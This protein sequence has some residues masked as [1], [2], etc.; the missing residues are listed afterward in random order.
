MSPRR[1]PRARDLPRS[2]PRACCALPALAG[3]SSERRGGQ[4]ARGPGHR[5]RRPGPGR[6]RRHPAL[7][8]GR[9]CPRPS[10]PS[11]RTPTRPR[12]RVA[13]RVLPSMFRLDAQ[14][15]PQR[16]ADYPG[17]REGRRH[18]AQA[19]RALQAQPAG[20][21]GATAA[22][23]APP[24]SPPSGA[25]C[26]ART[27]R[28]GRP[29]TPATTAS[30]R[31]SA[32][33][34][35]CEVRVTFARPY[36]DWRSLFS[37]L[38][39]KDVMGTPDAFNDGARRK[40]KVTAGP[41]AAA[42]GRHARTAQ[43]TL[44]RNPRW[45]GRPAKLDKMVPA[46]PC[47]ATSGPRRWPRARSTS[48]RSTRPTPGRIASRPRQ[49][50]AAARHQAQRPPQAA[51]WAS[52]R[53]DEEAAKKAAQGGRQVRPSRRAARLRRP[54]VPGARLHPARPQRLRRARSPTSGCGAP[55]PA[56]STARS[57]P[58]PSS[59]R[60]ACPP[61]RSAATSRWPGRPRTPTTAARSATRTPPRRRRCSPTRA[62]CRGGPRQGAE[63]EGREGRRRQRARRPTTRTSPRAVDDGHVHRRRGRQERGH[64]ERR[65]QARGQ[66]E[67]G[68]AGTGTTRTP[69]TTRRSTR[70]RRAARGAAKHLA[71]GGQ[72]AEQQAKQGGA[73]GAYAPKGTAAPAGAAAGTLAK[74]GKPLTLRF[75]LPSGAGSESLRTVA[76]RISPDAGAGRH[77]A[78]RSRRS[79]T[80][81]TSRTTSRPASTTSPCTPGPPPPSR[82]P[83]PAR[84]SPSR[85]R[86]PTARWTSSRT[87]PASAPTRST[88]SSTRRSPSWTSDDD[89]ALIRKADAR[90]W[91]AAGSIPLYQRPQLTAARKNVV[92]RGRLRLPDPGLRGH[93]LP[94]EG[95][96]AFGEPASKG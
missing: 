11:S 27:A 52:R 59:S 71:D 47:R 68:P 86:P 12:R 33:R 46:A 57:W 51:P 80:T 8:R 91:A 35:T 69:R 95:R 53:P 5:A 94:E 43:V 85:S 74:D 9:R 40:L 81:A 28:T 30:R 87:T 60:S 61:C 1:A 72:Y 10:T 73:P 62:G 3:C 63:G 2:S 77:H 21:C 92:E 18:R 41:F 44:V 36:A 20:A 4:A 54:Q 66:Q 16:N 17:V 24:T 38:Y 48:P 83:T 15:R 79:P 22:R 82:P 58:R 90:I 89:R 13:R 50:H 14:G 67:Q 45:W 29:A 19:G 76:D 34:T 70:T 7:G 96:E 6:R 25:P 23:S 49:G 78:R 93:G 32:A 39:P 64:Q 37:P 31:S 84:S 65:H 88:S 42:A 56:P 55:W 26:P 75:V